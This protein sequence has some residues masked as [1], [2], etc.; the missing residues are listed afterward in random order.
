MKI[1]QKTLLCSFDESHIQLLN[2]TTHPNAIL[3]QTGFI[4]VI[5][6]HDGFI[7][8]KKI[9]SKGLEKVIKEKTGYEVNL[10]EKTN[11][12]SHIIK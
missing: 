2:V 10:S 1:R 4:S 3:S 7:S 8:S 5:P 12:K 6:I 11:Q 9:D